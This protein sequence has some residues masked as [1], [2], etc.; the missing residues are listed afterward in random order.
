MKTLKDHI[1]EALKLGKNLSSFS[2]YSCQPKT[3]EELDK[4]INDRISKEGPECNLND[5]DVSL[6]DD[7]SALFC[8]HSMVTYPSGTLVK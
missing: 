6:I 7:M 8:H 3:K 1:N 4:I 5:I 2:T